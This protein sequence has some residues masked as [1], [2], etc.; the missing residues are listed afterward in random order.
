MRRF[1]VSSQ[2]NVDQYWSSLVTSGNSVL[3]QNDNPASDIVFSSDHVTD[4]RPIARG[5]DFSIQLTA[6]PGMVSISDIT[7]FRITML[8]QPTTSTLWLVK[9]TIGSLDVGVKINLD[10]SMQLIWAVDETII[11][12]DGNYSINRVLKNESLI[13]SEDVSFFAFS[14][15]N[16]VVTLTWNSQTI[17]IEGPTDSLTNFQFGGGTGAALVDKIG[18]S[19]RTKGLEISDY[20]PLFKGQRLDTVPRGPESTFS[21]LLDSY[22][23]EVIFLTKDSFTSVDEYS[24]TTVYDAEENAN[25]EIL[26]R[27]DFSIEYSDDDGTTWST[28]GTN[29]KIVDNLSSVVFRHQPVDRSD[30][31]IEVILTREINIPMSFFNA[32]VDGDLF[33]P[34]EVGVGYFDADAGDFSLGS[35]TITHEDTGPVRSV[36]LLGSIDSLSETIISY[37]GNPITGATVSGF[38]L[39]V[40]GEPRPF[41]SIKPGQIYHLVLVFDADAGTVVLN[42]DK[43]SMM[44]IVGLGASSSPYLQ[45]DA[46]YLFN[47]F[48]GNPLVSVLE[49][50][51]PLSDGEIEPGEPAVVLDLQWN[52]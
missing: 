36:E 37:D 25:W 4:N 52:K 49:I 51:D 8:V 7:D 26:K 15:R 10:T 33:L 40:N 21:Y 3:G 14:R 13:Y 32:V 17:S 29:T 11:D 48:V 6:D 42:P 20:I 44:K 16:G 35:V 22:Q 1:D 9:F 2:K 28:L 24:Y 47:T 41:S 27:A 38:T 50:T 39:Y 12:E 43:N 19:R 30:F 18:F 31:W 46:F 34:R 23:S 45:S 5:A